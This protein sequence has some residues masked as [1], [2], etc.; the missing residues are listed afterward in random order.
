M[1]VLPWTK[2]FNFVRAR[3]EQQ[4]KIDTKKGAR[5]T[6]QRAIGGRGERKVWVTKKIASLKPRSV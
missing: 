4:C 1:I 5:M 2:M 6:A 3:E